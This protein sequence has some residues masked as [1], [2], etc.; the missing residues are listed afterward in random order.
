ME[1]QEAYGRRLELAEMQFS[2]ASAVVLATTKHRQPLDL[3][4]V[5]THGKHEVRY[6]EIALTA[7]EADISAF[8]LQRCTTYIM[9]T[10]VHEAIKRLFPNAKNHD[11]L[12]IRSAY[13]ISKMIRDAFAHNILDPIWYID[14]NYQNQVLEIPGIIKL[15][16]SSL[17]EKRFDWRD[18][19]GPLA[20][21]QLSKFVRENILHYSRPQRT[22]PPQ[23]KKLMQQGFLILTEL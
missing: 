22:V 12:E 16:T 7:K 8:Y 23:T 15:D 1:S 19:G 13:L 4:T 14:K 2:L 5:W 20:L 17:N 11:K 18:Y 6:E 21:Y 10:Q 3:P 9:A